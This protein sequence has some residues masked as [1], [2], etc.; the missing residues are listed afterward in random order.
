MEGFQSQHT[1]LVHT[2]LLTA[3][4]PSH[5]S[6]PQVPAHM[7]PETQSVIHHAWGWE[8]AKITVIA[9]LSFLFGF[10]I[11]I[12]KIAL[13]KIHFLKGF[14]FVILLIHIISPK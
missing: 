7:A 13:T 6:Q 11:P 8:I 3:Q 2:P 10:H 9:S 12:L 4:A 14:I 5:P 1:G